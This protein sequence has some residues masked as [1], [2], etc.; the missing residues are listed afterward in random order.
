[1]SPGRFRPPYPDLGNDIGTQRTSIPRN[2]D[3][4]EQPADSS[5]YEADEQR[6]ES[7]H[8]D[9]GTHV[10]RERFQR[11]ANDDEHDGKAGQQMVSA[12]SFGVF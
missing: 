9:V 7:G 10:I 5:R 2:A 3:G 6:Y 8:R 12:I 1:M 11:S 4:R